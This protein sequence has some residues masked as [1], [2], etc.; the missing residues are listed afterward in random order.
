[1]SSSTANSIARSLEEIEQAGGLR[2]TD[3]ANLTQVSKATVSRWRT[4]L[5]RPQP[6]NEMVLSDLVYVVRRLQ[7]Y[8]TEE[9]IRTWLYSRHPQLGDERAVDLIHSGRTIDVLNVLNRLDSDGYL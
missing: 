4:G 2:G 9:E 7:D 3:I 6:R 5:A 1:M 8:Y